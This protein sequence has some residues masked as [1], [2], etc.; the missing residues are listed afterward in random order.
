MPICVFCSAENEFIVLL[1]IIYY[2]MNNRLQ[3]NSAPSP[4]SNDSIRASHPSSTHSHKPSALFLTQKK[5]N[6]YEAEIL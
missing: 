5:Q 2:Q 1:S 3:H 6:P 4:I